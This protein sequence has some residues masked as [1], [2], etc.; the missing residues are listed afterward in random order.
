[1]K[2]LKHMFWTLANIKY[3]LMYVWYYYFKPRPKKIKMKVLGLDIEGISRNEN[4]D[5]Y[6]FTNSFLTY[7]SCLQNMVELNAVSKYE[8]DTLYL[9]YDINADK[10]M[11]RRLEAAFAKLEKMTPEELEKLG[12]TR[13]EGSPE[14]LKH[15]NNIEDVTPASLKK[16]G[17]IIIKE[18]D[19]PTKENLP[20]KEETQ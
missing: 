18:L 14:D 17:I 16:H 13:T 6:K 9:D 1:M 7:K 11:A 15:C 19:E 12:I 3:M 2:T 20:T 10:V 4:A 5:M 8:D